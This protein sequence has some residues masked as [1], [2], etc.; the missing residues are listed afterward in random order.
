MRDFEG[1]LG[2]LGVLPHRALSFEQRALLDIK[3][4]ATMAAHEPKD[5][6]QMTYAAVRRFRRNLPKSPSTLRFLLS[7]FYTAWSIGD[8]RTERS[9]R[10]S[11]DTAMG[12]QIKILRAGGAPMVEHAMLLLTII[13]NQN[14]RRMLRYGYAEYVGLSIA[15]FTFTWLV[16]QGSWKIFVRY[17]DASRYWIEQAPSPANVRA[18]F[19]LEMYSLC[20]VGSRRSVMRP[21]VRR[22]RNG[23]SSSM[24]DCRSS[25]APGDLLDVAS[26]ARGRLLLG[27][28]RAR[29]GRGAAAA[30]A[31]RPSDCTVRDGLRL[32]HVLG[33]LCRSSG[34]RFE[35]VEAA[36]LWQSVATLHA[37]S[38]ALGEERPGLRAHAWAVGGG[39]GRSEARGAAGAAH[40][41]QGRGSGDRSGSSA[42]RG[43]G[44][45]AERSA[46]AVLAAD[47]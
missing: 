45:R 4:I 29:L 7:M 43:V 24:R 30:A 11:P 23:I 25:V 14:L 19:A 1:A 17:V 32:H 15:T 3:R 21:F 8:G 38:R 2:L 31:G 22:S 9:S 42:P 13:N 44:S 28:L 35:R 41:Y 26:L 20:L 18:Q 46:L 33:S 10:S 47:S 37:N 27:G 34:A 16:M 39:A 40:L 6:V 36:T 5:S 12:L